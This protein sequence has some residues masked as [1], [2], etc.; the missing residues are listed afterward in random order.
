M[1]NNWYPASDFTGGTDGCLDFIDGDELNNDDRAI[2]ISDGEI[3]FY[4][5][6]SSSSKT[7]DDFLYIVPVT[8]PGTKMWERVDNLFFINHTLSKD[9]YSKNIGIEQSMIIG[10]SGNIQ[11]NSQ[12]N[13]H[14]KMNIILLGYNAS[15]IGS[16]NLISNGYDNSIKSSFSG[17][18]AGDGNLILSDY[19]FVGGSICARTTI[20]GQQAQSNSCFSITGDAQKSSVVLSLETT[21]GTVADVGILNNYS[22]GNGITLLEAQTTK[23]VISIGAR[24]I[25]GSS[26]SIGDSAA[27]DIKALI[28]NVG[29][30]RSQSLM[31]VNVLPSV[32]D[33]FTIGSNVYTFTNE[34][35]SEDSFDVYIDDSVNDCA[36][37][38]FTSINKNELKLNASFSSGGNPF[39]GITSL[40][41]ITSLIGGIDSNSTVFTTSN[42]TALSLDGSGTLGGTAMG[43]SGV[44]SLVGA[45]T[46]IGVSSTCDSNAS[47]WNLGLTVD[48]TT[49]LIKI[50]CT[51]E[52][53]KEIHW[54][55]SVE[56]VE[57]G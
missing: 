6:N 37:Q 39:T 14:D 20:R 35:E 53:D 23:V 38:I 10:P 49:K 17:I 51:G 16:Y 43:V 2:L 29:A 18:I 40:I 54:V 21:D 36:T 33:I 4:I 56:M 31:E 28:K 13:S 27:W 46:G 57:V 1:S 25:A 45:A 3:N 52:A 22:G 47:A 12:G 7:A 34:D 24:Q 30:I 11:G 48:D 19:S 5:L 44:A 15:I 42:S 55:A 26:G 50:S 8:N 32:G 41:N 9:N